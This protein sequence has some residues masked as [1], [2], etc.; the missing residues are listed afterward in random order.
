MLLTL[1]KR[2][3]K[4]EHACVRRASTSRLKNEHKLVCFPEGWCVVS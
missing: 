1:E 3:E 2:S 4:K